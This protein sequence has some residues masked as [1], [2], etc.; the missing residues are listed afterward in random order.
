M[1]TIFKTTI[2]LLLVSSGVYGQRGIGTNSPD[3]SAILELASTSK[4]FLPPRMSTTERNGISTPPTGLVIYNTTAACLQWFNG[5][6]WFDTFTQTTEGLPNNNLTLGAITYQGKS[7]VDAIGI[8][9]NGEAVLAGSTIT[10][11]LNNTAGTEQGYGLSATDAGSGLIYAATGTILANATNVLVELTH[12]AMVMPVLESGLLTMALTGASNTIN[13]APRID[14]KSIPA[15]ATQVTDVV[16]GTQTWMDRNLGARRVATVDAP[17]EFTGINDVFSYGNHYQWGRPADGHEITVYNGTANNAGRGLADATDLEALSADAYPSYANFIVTDAGTKDWLATQAD[18][19]RWAIASQGPCPVNYHVPTQAEWTIA[20][21]FG[22]WNN[23]TD[24]FNSTLKLPSA[25]YRYRDNATLIRPAAF[26]YYWS[27]TV[28]NTNA[29]LL[30]FLSSQAGPTNF[31]R[32]NGFTVRCLK[33]TP[34]LAPPIIGTATAGANESVTVSYTAPA[35]NGGSVITAYTATSIPE[36]I[37]G[38]LAQAG[39]GDITVTGLTKG[40]AYTFTVTA[41]N[42]VSTSPASAASNPVTL[43]LF[44]DAP[45]IGTAMAGSASAAVAYTAPAANGGPGITSYT[46]TSSPGGFTGNIFNHSGSGTI[47]VAGLTNGT[48]YTFRVTATNSFGIGGVS[49]ASNGV[50][51]SVPAPSY[52]YSNN[53]GGIFTF[54]SHNLGADTSLDPHTP[55]KGLNG[56]YYQWGKNA[57]D[58]TVDNVIGSTWGDQGGT[59]ANGNWTPNSKGPNDPCPEGFRVP[60]QGEWQ[61]VIAS[62]SPSRTGTNGTTA[63]FGSALHFGQS[64]KQLTLPAAGRRYFGAGQLQSRGSSGLYWSSTESDPPVNA[65]GP[66]AIY[67]LFDIGNLRTLN[68]YGERTYG[69]SV[70]CFAE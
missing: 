56:D 15:S 63:E 4:G 33:E 65:S 9:Y 6:L 28:S 62:N 18:P 10:V 16:Y 7:V 54:M 64:G 53:T 3:T 13:L 40:S 20:D 2:M 5:V 48:Q 30:Y 27:S 37:T 14:I 67:L 44:P 17:N 35:S 34:S 45:G 26:G 32:A 8:G 11:V 24:T 31:T 36:G 69:Y 21:T 46:A 70:R 61:A 58:G 19:D 39:D 49:A 52:V 43:P 51:P 12:N 29:D 59:R 47:L 23:N 60:S 66:F 42:A 50:T 55:V 22:S 57:P 25:G 1:K 41:T 68:L 38:T